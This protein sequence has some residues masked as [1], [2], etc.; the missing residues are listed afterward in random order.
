MVETYS[1]LPL[2]AV[3][4]PLLSAVIGL[5]VPHY[6][7]KLKKAVFVLG[8]AASFAI[9]LSMLPS[10]LSGEV[11]AVNLFQVTPDL[12]LRFTIDALGYYYGLVISFIW[13][14]STIFALGYIEHK[15][16]QFFSFMAICNFSLLGVAFSQNM[17]SYFIFYEIMT[18]AA[19]PLII[20]EETETARRAGLKY[21][22]YAIP[23]SAVI[24]GAMAAHYF[25][26]GGNLSIVQSGTLNLASASRTILTVIFFAYLAGFG[27]KAAIMPLHGWVPDAHPEAPSPASAVLSGV[28]LKAGAFGIIRVVLNVFGMDLFR[29][30]HLG[31]YLAI[32]SVITIIFASIFAI[33]QDNLKRRLAYSSIS[34]VS[35]ILL[36]LSF[37]TY[38]GVLGGVMHLAHHALMKGCL[39]LGAGIIGRKTGKYNISEMAGIGRTLPLTMSA[40]TVA[41]LGMMGTP[42][43][44]G[45]LSKWLLG[46]G[47]L[48]AG[49]PY[50]I[51]ILLV[52]GFLNGIYFLPIIYTA[53]FKR[54]DDA[55]SNPQVNEISETKILVVP[56][57]VLAVLVI[58]GGL[59]ASA[60]Y[61][62]YALLNKIISTLTHG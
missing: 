61:F 25:W 45:F 23:A 7:H 34:Q 3:L 8:S 40:F 50:M 24:L 55:D 13:L 21:L 9:I 16:T 62:P 46:V 26:G 27:V 22:T 43:T 4:I 54:P 15:E 17:F 6:N 44:V 59:I 30:L 35:Y 12:P 5:S 20:H 18:F 38:S 48:E 31:T 47:A 57:L 2:I 60:P 36:G 10:V 14:L 1:I 42:P 49:E 51:A 19:Y 32:I 29:E 33:A 28:I 58:L 53:F 11:F 56:V 41:A 37:F 52:S 39:F